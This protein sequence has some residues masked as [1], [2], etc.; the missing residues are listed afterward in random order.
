[1]DT[2]YA[3]NGKHIALRQSVF[4]NQAEWFRVGEAD[5]ADCRGESMSDS[6]AACGD[7]VNFGRGR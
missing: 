5:V 7:D 2:G 4:S 3:G 6:F 1:L